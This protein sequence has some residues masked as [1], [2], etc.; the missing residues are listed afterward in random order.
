MFICPL[1]WLGIPAYYLMLGVRKLGLWPLEWLLRVYLAASIN[2]LSYSFVYTV[3]YEVRISGRQG[4]AD[5]AKQR[6]VVFNHISNLDPC[7][8]AACCWGIPKFMMKAELK[9][10]FPFYIPAVIMGYMAVQRDN[11]ESASACLQKA[12]YNL[13]V[14]NSVALAPEGTRNRGDA[15]K[16][17]PFKR[18]AF[19][20]S[21]DH[22]VPIC[23]VVTFGMEHI[24]P[25]GQ[26]MPTTGVV[27][28]HIL[29][30][31]MPREGE[32]AEEL[33]QRIHELMQKE[34]DNGPVYSPPSA[35]KSLALHLPAV[36]VWF[37]T[38][39]SAWAYFF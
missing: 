29:P 30:L 19:V 4:M 28:L 11:R 8:M 36:C 2:L 34:L 32:S 25:A 5:L 33:S 21:V 16:L 14:G 1:F 13:S 18:G 39:A 20:L 26:A 24:W 37:V 31:Q 10:F 7:T 35:F 9:V 15:R 3:G 12:V 17:M 38:L 22:K 27:Q 23:P 6:V